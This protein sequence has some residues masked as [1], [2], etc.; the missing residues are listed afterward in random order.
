V[1]YALD[2]TE[3]SSNVRKSLSLPGTPLLPSSS[4]VSISLGTK[5]SD[6]VW[7][8]RYHAFWTQKERNRGPAMSFHTRL[9]D[10]GSMAH[11]LGGLEDIK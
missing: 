8:H 11:Y 3:F 2:L 4:L 6:K 1:R 9:E 10:L 7:Y 5:E